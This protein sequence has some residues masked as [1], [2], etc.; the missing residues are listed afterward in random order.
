MDLFDM[1]G[2]V[3]KTV[4]ET[5]QRIDP[6]GPIGAAGEIVSGL[7]STAELISENGIDAMWNRAADLGEVASVAQGM[8]PLA[9]QTLIIQGGLKTVLG[10]QLQCG[11]TNT[12]ED[13]DGYSQSAQRFN[14]VADGLESAFPDSRWT[15]EGA[16]A[17]KSANQSQ[18]NRARRMPDADLDVLMAISSEAGAVENTRR[19]LNNAATLMGNAIAPALAARAIP[20]VG[21][22]M[23]LEIEMAVVGVSLPTCI[24]YMNRLSEHSEHS[25]RTMDKAAE[26]YDAIAAECYPT[27]M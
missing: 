24:W 19:I 3:M 18:K 10:M 27:Q 8:L 16:D 4:A 6:V 15:G 12:P 9:K 22:A 25:A 26:A 20:R 1:Y 11:W 17:Y 14:T 7:F 13:G 21:K 2:D 23:S 5:M